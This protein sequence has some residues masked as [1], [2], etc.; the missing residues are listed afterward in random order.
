MTDIHLNGK[1]DTI[2]MTPSWEGIFTIMLETWS[3]QSNEGRM[4][5]RQELRRVATLLDGIEPLVNA[6]RPLIDSQE[7]LTPE[8][9]AVAKAIQNI[10][11][12]SEL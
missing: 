5:Y 1:A 6:L 11:D 2:N 3:S 9:E 10:I 8:W 12:A 7:E 4:A